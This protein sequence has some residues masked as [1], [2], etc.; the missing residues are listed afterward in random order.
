MATTEE[1]LALVEGLARIALNYKLDALAVGEV[2]IAK[3]H[4]E[5]PPVKA[6]REPNEADDP[7]YDAVS[8]GL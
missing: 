2:K 7:L 8:R 5:Y 3:G 6:S 1:T 4:H